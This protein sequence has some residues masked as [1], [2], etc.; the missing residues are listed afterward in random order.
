MYALM[1]TEV[2]AQFRNRTSIFWTF[3]YP[4]IFFFVLQAVLA[5][6]VA[7]SPSKSQVYLFVGVAVLTV[8]S[9]SLFGISVV[10]CGLKANRKLDFFRV[11]PISTLRFF[12]SFLASRLVVIFVFAAIFYLLVFGLYIRVYDVSSA[13]FLNYMAIIMSVGMFFVGVG[14]FV[15]LVAKNA[16]SAIAIVNIINIPVLFLSDL[17]IPIDLMPPIVKRVAEWMPQYIGANEVRQLLLDANYRPD[18]TLIGLVFVSGCCLIAL[19]AH[20]FKWA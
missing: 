1:R 4:F 6:V 16:E 9:S 2:A 20:R 18:W 19:S 3:L 12:A 15:T 11:A 7:D 5:N 14:F 17:F 13:N 10:I 8:V